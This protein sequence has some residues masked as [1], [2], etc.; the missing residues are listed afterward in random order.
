MF[1]FSLVRRLCSFSTKWK[2][3]LSIVLGTGS[4]VVASPPTE[5]TKSNSRWTV[6]F[7]SSDPLNSWPPGKPLNK[8]RGKSLRTNVFHVK[9]NNSLG[10]D[11]LQR[12]HPSFWNAKGRDSHARKKCCRTS[13]NARK[14]KVLELLARALPTLKVNISQRATSHPR[15]DLELHS[16]D[17]DTLKPPSVLRVAY[18]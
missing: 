12:P 9:E 10:I 5:G 14:P 6:L 15:L 2:G 7:C 13:V 16:K 17:V 1:Q 11:H 18:N 8:G 4:D 3:H